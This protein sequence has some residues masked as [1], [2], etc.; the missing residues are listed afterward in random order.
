V[1][2]DKESN[3]DYLNFGEVSQLAVDILKSPTMLPVSLGI[4]GNW[5]AGKSSLLQLIDNN[6]SE[7]GQDRLV[8]N[9]DAWIYQGYDDSK[10]ALLEIIARELDKAASDNPSLIIKT[11]SLI[12]RINKLRV[13]GVAVEGAALAFGV[14]TG[15]ILAKGISSLTGAADGIDSQEEYQSAVK[16]V[17]EAGKASKDILRPTEA[18]TPPQHIDA[19]RKEYSEVLELLGKPV[20]VTIDNLDRCLPAN[21]IHTLEAI[22]LFLFLPNTAFIIAAD[23]DMIRTS[24][25]VHFKGLSERHQIDY[26]DKLIQI[27]IRVPKAGVLEIRSYL[28]MLYA[29]DSGIAPDKLEALRVGLENSLQQSWHEDPIEKNTALSLTGETQESDLAILYDLADRISPILA[30]SP[31]IQGNP[32][33]VKRLLNVVKMRSQIARRR[34]I[35]LDEGVIT[36]LVIFERC[37]G[38]EATA[39]LYRL[40]DT[41]L[42]KP[43]I[44]EE[45]ED[46]DAVGLPSSC[47][48]SWKN[49][50]TVNAFIKEWSMLAPSLKGSDLRAAIYLSRETM[51]VGSYVLGISSAGKEALNMLITVSK[52][53]S[54]TGKSVAEKIALEDH[55][56]VME[57]ILD[58]LRQVTGWRKQPEG[59]A[60]ALLLAQRSQEASKLLVRFI[61]GITDQGP[62]MNAALKDQ[63]WFKG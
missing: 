55:V 2:S 50:P 5:G 57:G 14:P 34:S 45:L 32:R 31:I 38:A 21:A 53:S 62:W 49:N 54:P 16:T 28:F 47:P 4:F 13:L 56:P 51:P 35:P 60:G 41:E 12:S 24:V 11:K 1:W 48:N 46:P 23:E 3:Q 59:F 29:I 8:I 10:T 36:K 17:Q 39:D 40:I 20:I 63:E 44:F 58:H 19:F 26:L 42:G 22:R 37:A 6:L 18:L 30:S 61:S 43:G 9:F 52:I 33:I 7:D 25:A 27:P 15:G